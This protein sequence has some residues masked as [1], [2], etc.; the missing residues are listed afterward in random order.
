MG[1]LNASDA[2]AL[3]LGVDH[4]TVLTV[5]AGLKFD[6]NDF[7]ETYPGPFEWDLKRLAASFAIRRKKIIYHIAATRSKFERERL[8][9]DEIAEQRLRSA[10]TNL[11]PNGGLQERTLNLT[12]YLDRYG[13]YFIDWVCRAIDLDDNGTVVGDLG[14]EPG[15][16]VVVDARRPERWR[17][18]A[19]PVDRVPGRI[20]GAV[21]APAPGLPA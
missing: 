15:Q 4:E 16:L 17:G 3:V 19:N 20:P 8:L 2:A 5:D 14:G 1:Q 21:N 6:I 10:L 12:Q 9:K 13:E 18:E 7:D 11:L